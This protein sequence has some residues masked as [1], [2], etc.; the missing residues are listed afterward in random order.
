M[1]AVTV[2][3]GTAG[4]V[5][6]EEVPEPDVGQGSVLVEA[7]AAGVCGTDAEIADGGYGWAPP[8]R[9]RLVLGHESLGRVVDPGPSGFVVG[10]HVVGVVRRPDPAPCPS[11]AVGEWDMCSNGRYTERGIKQAD[12]FMA[13]RWRIEPDYAVRVDKKLGTLGVL[14][15]PT[16]VVAKAWD[17]IAAIGRRTFWD[18]QTVLVTGAGPIGLLAALI[19]VEHG[20]ETHVLDRATSGPKPALVR[21]LGASYHTG[22]LTDLGFSPHI[23]VECTGVVQLVRQ[24]LDIVSPG[25]IVCLT[26]VGSPTA[27]DDVVSASALATDM[28]LKNIAAFGS[29]NANRRHYYRAAKVLAAADPAWL[30]QLITR[31]VPAEDAEQALQRTPEDIKVVIDFAQP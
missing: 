11:C 4:S 1:K 15:E 20:A 13:E 31:R 7:V 22:A 8:G 6:L 3:P 28:V 2:T 16:T 24:A 25:G 18:P 23:V 19:A 12:G 29:V 14:L 27:P 10:E 17:H 26:G 21:Q 9:D 5:R 30:E